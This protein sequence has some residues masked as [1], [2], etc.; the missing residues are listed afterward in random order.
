MA[1]HLRWVCHYWI[2]APAMAYWRDADMTPRCHACGKVMRLRERTGELPF[3]VRWRADRQA[4]T[5]P[6]AE[7]SVGAS[8]PAP[9][10]RR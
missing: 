2:P 8:S 3:F 9:P 7:D 6:M 5:G 1:L 4:S 10:P